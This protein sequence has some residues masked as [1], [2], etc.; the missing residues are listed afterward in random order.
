MKWHQAHTTWFFE[1]FVL[2]PF[3]K[4][5]KPFREEF[6]WL[7]NSYY[8]SLGQEISEKGRD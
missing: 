3:L 6:Q 8:N 5:Y 7:F 4:G 1:T 2:C